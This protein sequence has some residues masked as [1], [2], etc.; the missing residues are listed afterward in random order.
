MGNPEFAISLI[1]QEFMVSGH[2]YLPNDR[3]FSSV[4]TAKHRAKYLYVPQHWYELVRNCRR[5][6]PF[7]VCE[8]ETSDFVSLHGLK[9]AIVNR[10]KNE[11]GQSVKWLN[12]CWIR[13]AK[14][15]PLQFSY[16]YSH[17]TL[18]C[19]RT[20]NLRRKTKPGRPVDMGL[21]QIP[22][23]FNPAI[24]YPGPRQISSAKLADLK[25]L[26]SYI[27]LYTMH[28]LR[29]SQMMLMVVRRARTRWKL[30]VTNQ[31]Q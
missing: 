20:V 17:N 31:T 19:W 13:V 12:I 29:H 24:L 7:R 10:K 23:R 14:E 15:K 2:S 30:M 22:P 6:N 27:P 25:E 9:T 11:L 28:S 8:I 3:D 26:L 4:E 1:D 16:K 5:V 21:T 18:E